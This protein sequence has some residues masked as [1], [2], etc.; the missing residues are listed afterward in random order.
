MSHL[1]IDLE[2]GYASVVG[3]VL[4]PTNKD[5]NMRS[6]VMSVCFFSRFCMVNSKNKWQKGE[7]G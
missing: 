7:G 1:I 4:R 2:I 3:V 6:F 5:N